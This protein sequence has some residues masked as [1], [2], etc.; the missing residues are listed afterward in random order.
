MNHLGKFQ[1]QLIRQDEAADISGV[2]SQAIDQLVALNLITPA[3]DGTSDGKLFS[4]DQTPLLEI[5]AAM[6]A[7]NFR[8]EEMRDMVQVAEI[9]GTH[10]GS[11]LAARHRV[12]LGAFMGAMRRRP[13]STDEQIAARKALI[14]ALSHRYAWLT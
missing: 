8:L 6:N 9:L 14:Q 7:L 1:P 3:G 10:P 12:R 11:E 4:L 5:L 2:P 13:V